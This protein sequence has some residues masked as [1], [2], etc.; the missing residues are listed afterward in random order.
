MFKHLVRAASLIL[1]SA[2]APAAIG[3]EPQ[4]P[5]AQPEAMP[6]P[7]VIVVETI[8]LPRHTRWVWS[9]YAPNSTGRL[10]RIVV[11]SP[12][13]SYYLRDGEPYPWTTTQPG[14]VLPRTGD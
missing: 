5:K 12:N 4:K 14:L 13:G 8:P 2:M 6:A 10:R 7:Q 11:L 9:N 3:D 1:F